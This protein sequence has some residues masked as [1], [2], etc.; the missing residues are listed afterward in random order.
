[1]LLAL[2]KHVQPYTAANPTMNFPQP[3]IFY[4]TA[5]IALGIGIDLD[6]APRGRLKETLNSLG[7]NMRS[8]DS[9]VTDGGS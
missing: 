9:R 8:T 6:S 1:M 2:L 3:R 5:I 4:T 7:G